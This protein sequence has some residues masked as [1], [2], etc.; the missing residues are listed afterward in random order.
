[1]KGIMIQ[2]TSSDAGKSYIATALCRIFANKGYKVSPFKSQNMS[3]NS[4]VTFD[5][6]E[7]GRAQG[8]QA[9]AAKSEANVHMNPIL[10]KP[11]KDTLS[12]VVL[13]GEVFNKYTGMGYRKEFTLTKGLEAVKESLHYLDKNY[14]MV[15]IE[16]AGSPAEVNLNDREIVNMRIAEAADVDVL[17][18][19]N[20]D[21]GGSFA[22]L[23]GTLELVAEHRDRIKGVIFNKFRG[24]IRLLQDGLDWFEEYTG[25]KVAG[26]IPYMTDVY[27]ETEDAQSKHL[28][29]NFETDNALDIAV[30]HMERVSNNTDLEPFIHE[31]DVS[32]RIVKKASEFGNPHAVIIPGTKSTIGDLEYLNEAKLSDKIKN[33]YNNGGTVFGICGGYQVLGEEILDPKRVDS[34]NKSECKGIGLLPIKTTFE[35]KKNVKNVTGE[36]VNSFSKMKVSGYEIHLGETEYLNDVLPFVKLENSKF[37]GCVVD[38]GRL[39]GT[40]LHNIF[41]NDNFRNE[42]LNKVRVKNGF[43]TFEVVDTSKIK[44]ESY[45]KLAKVVEEHLDMKLIESMVFE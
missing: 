36:V 28:L 27:I 38:G 31:K 8:V 12:E 40:Y 18:V 24:D 9:E 11:M 33:Y 39:I 42:W 16:G 14:D 30:I 25:V 23:V 17:L 37:D 21:L 20:I 4:Y 15:V 10:L 41:H 22:S 1:M 45:E 35:D 34:K 43:E 44:E 32:I 29:Y 3:N 5:G 6:K 2:G 7:I 13:H 26:V 19:T